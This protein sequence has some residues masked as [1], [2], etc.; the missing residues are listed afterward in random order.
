MSDKS[1]YWNNTYCVL[2]WKHLASHPAGGVTPCCI[3]DH[4]HSIN[5]ARNFNPSGRDLIDNERVDLLNLNTHTITDIM[6]SDYFKQIRLQMLNGEKP[7]ACHRC[8]EEEEA[9]DRSKRIME[10]ERFGFDLELAKQ[11]TREDG[12]IPVSFNFIELRLGNLCNIKCRTCNPASSSKWSSEYMKMQDRLDFVTK[13]EKSIDSQWTESDAFWQDLLDHSED[14]ELIYINGGEPTL[15]EKHWV[16][17]ERLIER[18][19]NKQVTLWYNINMTNVPDK[20]LD[21]WKQFKKV[22]VSC[23]IDDLGARNDYIRY[24]SKWQDVVANLTK[25]QD[26]GWIE[27]S[28]NQTISWLNVW[29][30]DEF[31]TYMNARNIP[32]H[33]N[34]VHDPAYLSPWHLPYDVK[35]A[36]INKTESVMPHW[37]HHFLVSNLMRDSDLRLLRQG[38]RYNEWLDKSRYKGDL[39]GMNVFPELYTELVVSEYEFDKDDPDY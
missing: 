4:T 14:V 26:A 19:L 21:L 20:L 17:L 3:S 34:M 9:G 23:S 37:Q 1:E 16:Y 24:G 29:Y 18:G 8:Y 22:T 39:D 25:L 33:L 10:S 30:V 27:V 11:I 32:V 5:R 12:S 13:Y 15:V 35:Q 7:K 38:M 6:N 31:F 2:P 28:V 36:I